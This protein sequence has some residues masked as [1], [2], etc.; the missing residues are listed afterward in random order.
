[1]LNFL[2]LV[3]GALALGIALTVFL[4]AVK[5]SRIRLRPMDGRRIDLTRVPPTA[6]GV[7]DIGRAWLLPRG[8]RYLSS[9]VTRPLIA[10]KRDDVR[11]SDVYV[12]ETG[13]VFA[14]VSLRDNPQ[15]GDL[16]AIEF[17]SVFDDAT[18]MTTMNRYR[19]SPI[20][21]PDWWKVEDPYDANLD[22][23][24]KRHRDRLAAHPTPPSSDA[25][26]RDQMSERFLRGYVDELVKAG[27]A[28]RDAAGEVR[29][30]FLPAARYVWKVLSGN[31]R[32]NLVT[33]VPLVDG[34]APA[35]APGRA[36]AIDAGVEAD[37]KS[38]QAR[39]AAA[40]AAS[41]R[42]KWMFGLLSALAFI[43][44]GAWIWS[45][46][47]AVGIL[48]VIA[49]HEGGHYL[50]MKLV[51]YRN[52]HVFFVPGLGGLA[53]GEKQDASAAQK[54]FVYLAGPVPGIAL[55][56][57]LYLA[58]P[59]ETLAAIEGAEA[60]LMIMLVINVFNLLPVTPLDGG[61]VM[62][63]LLFAR[64]P[65]LRFLFAAASCALLIAGG[66]LTGDN[67]MMLIGVLVAFALP[68]Q[69]R[70][71]R[72]ARKIPRERG[73]AFDEPTA[74]RKVFEALAAPP[75]TKWNFQKRTGAADE[76]ISELRTPIPGPFG[77]LGGL[78]VYAACFVVPAVAAIASS[79]AFR[80]GAA[81]A[82]E[83]REMIAEMQREA[84][85]RPPRRDWEKDL[86]AARGLSPDARLALLVEAAGD[87]YATEATR[88]EMRRLAERRTPG[89]AL[90]GQALLACLF[91]DDEEDDPEKRARKRDAL[92]QLYDEFRDA[93]ADALQVKGNI[94]TAL[95][96]YLEAGDDRVAML[97]QGRDILRERVAPGDMRVSA[98]WSELAGE[99]QALDP[100]GSAAEDEWK[101]LL[102]WHALD[103]S[104][105]PGRAM[106]AESARQGYVNLLV[107]QGRLAE[108]EAVLRPVVDGL[109]ADPSQLKGLR[110][111]SRVGSVQTLF[112]LGVAREDTAQ[113]ATL[114]T[115][116]EKATP[117]ARRNP[118]LVVARL[119]S[120]D[121][122]RDDAG[123]AS[124][125]A[126]FTAL[127][128]PE[129]ACRVAPMFEGTAVAERRSAILARHGVCRKG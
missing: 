43:A 60:L 4:N 69:W 129:Y 44:V 99:R 113:A 92:Q 98:A 48:L 47:L 31:F 93:P 63:V 20:W 5:I 49:F 96:R 126:D 81:M 80:E 97:A 121:L 25:N 119:V 116:W 77:V 79:Q 16:V 35:A 90:R 68:A 55:A 89:D 30:R 54:V 106:M 75:F 59:T 88:A 64:W 52:L 103:S 115:A 11:F 39:R 3:V 110:A 65:T 124:A 104:G 14:G 36:G 8:F 18:M 71:S 13:T 117:S 51:G 57:A 102:A 9:W 38:Y 101:A 108:A 82:W 125:R 100:K 53:T 67:V 32:A 84:S 34:A 40:A 120:A 24:L 128:S 83:S 21:E 111:F 72:L 74:A 107:K 26:L 41:G 56:T 37:L 85:S 105:D 70:F 61:R 76:L 114:V 127:P 87:N 66:M 19:H 1:M 22:T 86:E 95:A 7:L 118:Q 28:A 17:S 42:G 2:L 10:A 123:I 29:L 45:A 109:L 122:A 62:E 91:D 6:R 15:P 58:V 73:E 12:D 27:Y 50:A 112:W 94:A 23:A 33:P 78:S 46:T